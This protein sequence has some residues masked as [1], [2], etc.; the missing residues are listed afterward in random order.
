MQFGYILGTKTGFGKSS[1]WDFIFLFFSDIYLG[2]VQVKRE[3]KNT[4]EQD[5]F[6]IYVGF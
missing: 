5:P 4:V 2:S 6:G 3:T 1:F